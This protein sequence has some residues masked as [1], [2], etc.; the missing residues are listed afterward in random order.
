MLSAVRIKTGLLFLGSG[1]MALSLASR[2]ENHDITFTA[3]IRD[4]TCDMQIE[5]GSGDGTNNVIPIGASGKVRLD[6]IVLKNAKAT[7][8][9]K[10]KMVS[11]PSSLTSLK[12]TVSGIA[13][14]IKTAIENSL[15]GDGSA[16]NIGVAIARTATPDSPFTVNST[17]DSQRLIW[18][19][20]E[21]SSGEVSLIASLVETKSGQGTTGNFSGIATFNFTYE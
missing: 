9:F 12:T 4:T 18:S 21:I 3:T 16:E 15:S 2:A 17:T 6:Y 19:S 7:T 14:P 10:L 13:S 8:S 5:G 11:C 1:L 20:A